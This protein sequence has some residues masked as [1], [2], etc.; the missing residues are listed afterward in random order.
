[1]VLSGSCSSASQAQTRA[2]PERPSRAWRSS[3]PSSWPASFTVESAA[4]FVRAHLDQAPVVYSTA[5]PDARRAGPGEPRPGGRRGGDRALL[6]RACGP[7]GRGRCHA[8][9]GR[10]RRDL[11]CRRHRPGR[12]TTCISGHEIDPGVPALSAEGRRPVRLALKSGNFGSGGLLREGAAR[13]GVAMTDA[14]ADEAILRESMVRWGRSLFERGLTV[15]S[16]GNMSARIDDGYLFTPTNSCLGFLEPR[17]SFEARCVGPA[18]RR[19]CR[20]PRNCRSTWPSTRGGRP[21]WQW[22]T[23]IRPSRPLSPALPTP[24]PKTPSRRSRPTW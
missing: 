19:R 5:D 14:G 8:P 23:C 12:A 9:C 18:H 7:L 16:S 1:M 20:R 22:F 2:L 17:A 21:P 3:R 24:T 11:R 13:A 4:A 6:R 15:G 10:G